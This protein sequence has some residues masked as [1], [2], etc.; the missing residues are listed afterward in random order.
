MMDGK[1]DD[2]NKSIIKTLEKVQKDFPGLIL[3]N[4]GIIDNEKKIDINSKDYLKDKS[5]KE[6]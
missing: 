4:M 1:K 3:P 5:I 6:D 2:N